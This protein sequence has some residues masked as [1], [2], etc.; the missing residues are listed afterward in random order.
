[1]ARLQTTRLPLAFSILL[2]TNYTCGNIRVDASLKVEHEFPPIGWRE[3]ELHLLTSS[4]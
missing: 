1:M 2:F 4:A 3:M